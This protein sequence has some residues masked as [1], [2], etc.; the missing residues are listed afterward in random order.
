M[1]DITGAKESFV[2]SERMTGKTRS[3]SLGRKT[4]YSDRTRFDR[5]CQIGERLTITDRNAPRAAVGSPL[6]PAH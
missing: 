1:Q 6:V 4:G 5:R 2:C 3:Y